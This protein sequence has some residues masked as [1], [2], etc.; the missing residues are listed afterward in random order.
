MSL[1]AT[2]WV[3]LAVRL[4]VSS[5]WTIYSVIHDCVRRLVHLRASEFFPLSLHLIEHMIVRR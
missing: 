3:L 1:L 4:R 2:I 5:S